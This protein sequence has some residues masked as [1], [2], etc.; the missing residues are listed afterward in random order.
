MRA[1][2]VVVSAS[3]YEAKGLWFENFMDLI[4]NSLLTPF[5]RM[6]SRYDASPSEGTKNGWPVL[7]ESNT[8][9]TLKTPS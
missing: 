8:S 2:G 7:G 4:F 9:S 6:V 3:D 5:A 1:F